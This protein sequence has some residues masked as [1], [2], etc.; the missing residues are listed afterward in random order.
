MERKSIVKNNK[1]GGL[2]IVIGCVAL[3]SMLGAMLLVV[4]NNNRR[5]K[6]LERQAQAS[7]YA[8]ESGS[9]TLVSQLEIEAEDAIKR[10]FADLMV[11]YSLFSTPEERNQRFGEFFS[12]AFEA[13]VTQSDAAKVIM[14]NA[15]GVDPDDVD[16]DI[17][18]GT[19]ETVSLSTDPLS[20]EQYSEVT[21]RNAT[22]TYSAGG[23]ETSVSTDIKVKTLIPNVDGSVSSG[24][25]CDFT[26]F[27]LIAGRDI[28]TELNT[29]QTVTVNGNLYTKNSLRHNNELMTLNVNNAKKFLVGSEIEIN[30]GATLTVNGGT[31]ASGDGVWANG[32][33]V[34]DGG[35]LYANSNFYVS[36]D[37][38]IN[39]IEHTGS[40]VV[41]SG[42][43][44]VGYSGGDAA[45]DASAASSAITIN[46]A[47]DIL[48]DLSGTTNL[49]LTGRSY[50]RD[51]LWTA[52]G[53]ANA[54]GV[55][56]GES[57]AYKDMQSM[58][59]VPGECLSTKHN[60]MTLEEYNTA[61]TTGCLL[62]GTDISYKVGYTDQTFSFLEYLDYT[63]DPTTGNPILTANNY[64]VRHVKLDGG[65]TE[66]VY[67]Y[68]NFKNE[69]LAQKYFK[70]YMDIPELSAD[71]RKR[72]ANLGA[73]TIKLATNNYTLAN[74]FTYDS[75]GTGT[76]GVQEA[77]T[78]L[79][80]L[81]GTQLQAKTR[82]NSLFTYL[83]KDASAT[84][85]R[86][87]D[88]IANQILRLE[89]FDSVDDD[90][91]KKYSY[92]V[93]GVAY[94]FWV[95]DGDAELTLES[96]NKA[97]IILVNGKLS[98]KKSSMNFSGLILATGGVKADG[99][100]KDP[101]Q[102]NAVEIYSSGTFTSNKTAVEALLTVPEVQEYFRVTS[103]SGGTPGSS[104]LSSEAVTISFENWKKN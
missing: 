59:L 90:E 8:A 44:Y 86:G 36:D 82:T 41:I 27:A 29:N 74:A 76:Y 45:V 24:A 58:Y 80:Y 67:L 81:S 53:V 60:P 12:K 48:L 43:E 34:S 26:D 47:K 9:E 18:F 39:A 13:E 56:Q 21:I 95:Y 92:T 96:P 35:K 22:F 70:D 38:T 73:S 63:L 2:I 66:F 68:L 98:L 103:G 46:T 37:L 93:D 50:I 94:D 23:T 6:D 15:L 100:E 62:T 10:A 79:S 87:Y 61:A 104:Y 71:I 97:G 83:R 20:T 52:G 33:T 77:T 51:R 32:V 99:S 78:A 42:G 28:T 91:W 31:Q 65:A 25:G 69:Q 57:V 64:V 17:T 4:T 101:S 84:T 7:F 75:A 85:G 54:L 49:V 102:T 19:V 55:L 11:Q 88:V 14:G 16:V 5:M 40:Q 89:K 1:G 72:L 3:L 30:D